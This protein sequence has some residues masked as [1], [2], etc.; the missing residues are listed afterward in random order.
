LRPVFDAQYE[1]LDVIG[2]TIRFSTLGNTNLKPAVSTATEVGFNLEFLGRFALEASYIKNVIDDQILLVPLASAAGFPF[3]WQNA[4]TME[5]EV[6]EARFNAAI[7]ETKGFNWNLQLSFD[8]VK[9]KITQLNVAP[10]LQGNLLASIRSEGVGPSIFLVDEGV[11]FGT[12]VGRDFARS[13]DDVPQTLDDLGSPIPKDQA[14]VINEDGY[15]VLASKYH[16]PG[17]VPIPLLDDSGQLASVVIGDVNPD[18][19][20]GIYNTFSWGNLSASILLDW[21]QGGDIYNNTRQNLYETPRHGDVDQSDRP[22]EARKPVA[23]YQALYA[24][25]SSSGHFVEDGSYLKLREVSLNYRLKAASLG[26]VGD[27]I[28]QI[29]IGLTG[30][31]LFTITGYSGFDPEVGVSDASLFPYDNFS[32]P[33]FRKLTARLELTF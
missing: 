13:F 24:T 12:M 28:E 27:V 26:K 3:Q 11:S 31:N 20:L 25:N 4:G 19:Q 5:S 9:Q 32:Y 2:G 29:T 1:T 8:R 33:N 17:E 10:F 14:Y 15:V 16:T 23:Y 21:K 22:L 7:I 6:F 30:R 18:F